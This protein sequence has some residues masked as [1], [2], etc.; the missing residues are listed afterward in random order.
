MT[1]DTVGGVW[2]Y[3]LE[4]CEGLGRRGVHVV[5]CTMGRPLADDQWRDAERVPGV[6][7]FEST[8]RLEWMDDP[9]EEVERAGEWL[10]EIAGRVRPEVVHLNNFCHGTLPWPAPVVMVGHSCVLSWFEAVRGE[11]APPS[12]DRYRQ[13]VTRG[14]RAAS[15]VVAPSRDMLSALERHYGPFASARVIANARGRVRFAS[16]PTKEPFILS[17]GR[18]WDEAKNVAALAEIASELPWPVRVAGEAAH[19]SRPDDGF[20]SRSSV[21]GLGRLAPEALAV[22]MSRAAI[23]ALPARYEPFGLSPL[24][25]ALSGCAL[26]LGDIPSLRE[27]W[28]D[29]AVFVPPD[30]QDALRD[31]LLKLIDDLPLRMQMSHRART[32]AARYDHQAFTD[33][34]LEEYGRISSS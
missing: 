3:A 30:D 16:A 14:L 11:P 23:Y 6:E 32:R 4:L 28:G 18:L 10:L 1:A 19:P 33:A 15:R 8:Y 31:A 26:V 2:T 9:W 20:A 27:I 21:E 34:W 17:A 25:A 29:A 22:E 7:L 24:E 13:E 5:L 12:W